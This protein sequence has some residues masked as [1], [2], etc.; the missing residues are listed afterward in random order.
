MRGGVRWAFE[1]RLAA[2]GVEAQLSL[3]NT[4]TGH[5]FPT[6]TVPEV[7]LRIEAVNQFGVGAL[8]AEKLIGR[9]S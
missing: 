8:V 2:G 9:R 3:T 6:Y 5:A 1:T 7:W 4:D